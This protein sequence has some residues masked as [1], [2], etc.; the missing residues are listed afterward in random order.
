M[1]LFHA[2]EHEDQ[3][4]EDNNLFE[5]LLQSTEMEPFTDSIFYL[6]RYLI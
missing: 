4:L 2:S 3:A 5:L 1:L 6:T